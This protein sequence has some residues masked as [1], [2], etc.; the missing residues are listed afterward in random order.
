MHV[1]SELSR[2]WH[3]LERTIEP[4]RSLLVPQAVI[5]EQ[6]FDDILT[7]ELRLPGESYPSVEMIA[8]VYK[9]VDTLYNSVVQGV[10]GIRLHLDSG[11]LYH[12]WF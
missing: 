11:Y 1:V 7:L 9:N 3:L 8:S 4:L 2:A 12:Q 5:N 10:P 6:P